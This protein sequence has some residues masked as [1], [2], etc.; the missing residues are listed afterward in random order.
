MDYCEDCAC[1]VY[2]EHMGVHRCKKRRHTIL[3]PYRYL[4]CVD[5]NPREETE[6]LEENKN[7]LP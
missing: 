5:F 2:D 6:L 3:M 4:A 7:E 1:C